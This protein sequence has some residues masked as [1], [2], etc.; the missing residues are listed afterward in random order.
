MTD[1]LWGPINPENWNE[2]PHMTDR[3]AT[4]KDVKEGRAVFFLGE[5]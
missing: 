3:L 1:K 2:I 4:K 5:S